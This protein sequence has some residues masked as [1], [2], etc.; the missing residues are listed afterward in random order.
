MK[1]QQSQV[2]LRAKNMVDQDKLDINR[3]DFAKNLKN[4]LTDYMSFSALTVDIVENKS[5]KLVLCVTVDGVKK[6]FQLLS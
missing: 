6:N 2:Y 3:E 4:F 5:R 1:N